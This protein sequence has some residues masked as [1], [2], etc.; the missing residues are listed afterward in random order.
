MTA[1]RTDRGIEICVEDDGP[2]IPEGARDEVLRSGSRLDTSV[3]GTGLG[4]SISVDLLAAYGGK[5]ELRTSE[6]RGGLACEVTIG[7]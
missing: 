6:R 7:R 2:G 1:K 5:L 4:L 3:R